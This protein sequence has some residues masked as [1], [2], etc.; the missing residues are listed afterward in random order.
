MAF[1]NMSQLLKN[2]FQPTEGEKNSQS[3][4]TL[5]TI[6]P[7]NNN[8]YFQQKENGGKALSSDMQLYSDFN[9]LGVVESEFSVEY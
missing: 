6:E 3:P 8:F 4:T 7:K 1:Y 2:S 5:M 9:W